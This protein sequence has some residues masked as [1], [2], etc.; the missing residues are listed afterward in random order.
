MR[1]LYVLSSAL[2]FLS[3]CASNPAQQQPAMVVTPASQ[4]S[5]ADWL[6]DF[7]A[8]ALEKGISTKTVYEVLSDIEPSDQ[9]V[10]L[11]RRQMEF[12]LTLPEYQSRAL[13]AKRISE[14]KQQLATHRKVLDAIAKDSGVSP[15]VVVALWGMET[16]YGKNTGGFSV[17]RALATLAWDG[18][19]SAYFRGELL[20]ALQILDSGS[21]TS[22]RFTGSW[23]GAMGQCQFM[24][25]TYL[26]HAVDF[27]HDGRRD[28]WGTTADV[29]ASA[30]NYLKN[31]G[32]QK[33]AAIAIP[34][35][36]HKDLQPGTEQAPLNKFI[37]KGIMPAQGAMPLS[38]L[39]ETA[40]LVI[41]DAAAPERAF[42]VGKNYE[43]ILTW[44]RSH[45][46]A[47]T[48]AELARQLHPVAS[49]PAAHKSHKAAKSKTSS[50]K[51]KK[52]H[53]R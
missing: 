23:A 38:S 16:N 40:R 9:V 26:K 24:P 3:G 20:S 33:G 22:N 49:A 47:L 45:R 5:F 17:I 35:T 6:Q 27:D 37:A 11:D 8:E 53:Q 51:Q 46:F 28:I 2:L 48:V 30:A 19:R 25:S 50:H 21:I 44:N 36:G 13:T 7:R 34:I 43:A 42:L 52:Q 18:R 31:S 14:G 1:I 41:P 39:G 10:A 29:F 4:Q 15:E 12:V 32:W